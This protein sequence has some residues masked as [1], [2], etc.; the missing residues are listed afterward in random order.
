MR[1]KCNVVRGFIKI[2]TCQTCKSNAPLFAFDSETDNDT[3]GLCSAALCNSLDV[4]IA[5]TTLDEWTKMESGELLHLPSRLS[6][7][8]GLKNLHVLHVKRI[9]QSPGP[10]AGMSFSEFRKLYKPPVVIYSCPCCDG[11]DAI[12]SQEFSVSKFEEI[13][14]RVVALGDLVV[15]Q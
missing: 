14:G 1:S 7:I 11:G 2:I 9:E 3:V 5:E 13:G 12:E 4:V 8:S 15:G 10:A 6:S